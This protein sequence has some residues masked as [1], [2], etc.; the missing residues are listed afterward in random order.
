[1]HLLRC[2]EVVELHYRKIQHIPGLGSAPSQFSYHFVV[3]FVFSVSFTFYG[4]LRMTLN[5]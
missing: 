1:M 3:L 5:H 4:G 2:A